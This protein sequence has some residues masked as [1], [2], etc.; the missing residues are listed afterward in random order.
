MSGRL[1]EN[2]ADDSGQGSAIPTPFRPCPRGD[3]DEADLALG[4]AEPQAKEGG[5]GPGGLM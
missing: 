5:S 4:F 1:G 3:A 2:D